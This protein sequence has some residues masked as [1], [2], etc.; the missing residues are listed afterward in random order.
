[1]DV[2]RIITLT[3]LKFLQDLEEVLQETNKTFVENFGREWKLFWGARRGCSI[4]HPV[5]N[6]KRKPKRV[7]NT[8]ITETHSSSHV[9][10]S[11]WGL[12]GN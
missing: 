6:E 11:S 2:S 3:S 9:C 4:C 12:V 1:M 7:D 5:H 8:E 10:I